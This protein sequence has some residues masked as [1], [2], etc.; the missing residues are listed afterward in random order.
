M[1]RRSRLVALAMRRAERA[2]ATVARH[3]PAA[4]PWGTRQTNCASAERAL[5]QPLE[6]EGAPGFSSVISHDMPTG[7]AACTRIVE[8]GRSSLLGGGSTLR[9]EAAPLADVSINK[10][11][12][13]MAATP[14][15]RRSILDTG[16]PLTPAD[17]S[18]RRQALYRY[19]QAHA[20]T[21][22]AH[23]GCPRMQRTDYN[24]QACRLQRPVQTLDGLYG[25]VVQIPSS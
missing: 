16:G 14:I 17:V 2:Q 24:R 20:T 21:A 22:W 13:A 25:V 5:R 6:R 4:T 1:V 18:R 8:P 10:A 15:R 9:E 23:N 19:G 7:T 12:A 11:V 3:C